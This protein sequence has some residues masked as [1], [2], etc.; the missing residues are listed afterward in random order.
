M[1][2]VGQSLEGQNLKTDLAYTT[3]VEETRESGRAGKPVM[4]VR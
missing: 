3:L 1:Q 2:T 4:Q